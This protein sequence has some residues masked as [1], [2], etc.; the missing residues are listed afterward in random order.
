VVAISSNDAAAYVP[1]AAKA[2]QGV[3]LNAL[4]S[5]LTGM[6]QQTFKLLV[7]NKSAIALSK[8]EKL[9]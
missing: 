4:I 2:S 8:K 1:M 3:W 7:D 6:D 9:G 5:E